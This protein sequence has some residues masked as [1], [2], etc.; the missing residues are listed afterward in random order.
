[1]EYKSHGSRH[2]HLSSSFM[3]GRRT[4]MVSYHTY[5]SGRAT[6]WPVLCAKACAHPTQRK[7]T[8]EVL[9]K[10]FHETSSSPQ[11]LLG[12]V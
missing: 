5:P 11:L 4:I 8:A 7:L 10:T 3:S 6:S 9:S 2:A 12:L 1:M